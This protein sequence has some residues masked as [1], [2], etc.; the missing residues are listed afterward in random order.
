M[1]WEPNFSGKVVVWCHK[2]STPSV[3][4]K[5]ISGKT[6]KSVS[7]AADSRGGDL[8]STWEPDSHKA[9]SQNNFSL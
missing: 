4:F 9:K 2:I 1:N 7:P 3:R 5:L 6:K 8:I